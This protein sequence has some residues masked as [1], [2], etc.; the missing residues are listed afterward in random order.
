VYISDSERTN[1]RELEV[2][3]EVDSLQSAKGQPF[4]TVDE[5]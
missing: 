5:F 1:K 2:I 4:I 3:E